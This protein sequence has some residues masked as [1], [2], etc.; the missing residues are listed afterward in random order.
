VHTRLRNFPVYRSNPLQDARRKNDIHFTTRKS[1]SPGPNPASELPIR[2]FGAK[3]ILNVNMGN[4]APQLVDD[5]PIDG[6]PIVG[7]QGIRLDPAK[8]FPEN[9]PAPEYALF[10]VLY[11][12]QRHPQTL[13]PG[14]HRGVSIERDHCMPIAR[15]MQPDKLTKPNLRT[16]YRK[17]RENMK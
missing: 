17:S 9:T 8:C 6:A 2:F 4:W 16:A 3:A 7:D 14:G 5:C 10:I 12:V 15:A 1:Q 13:Q 11:G